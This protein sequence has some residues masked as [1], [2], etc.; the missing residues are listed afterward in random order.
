[1]RDPMSFKGH[2]SKFKNH[3]DANL[4]NLE[5]HIFLVALEGA[6]YSVDLGIPLDFVDAADGT[7][8]S[9]LSHILPSWVPEAAC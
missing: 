5:K 4:L 6:A 3:H 2:S 1:M 9:L 8:T 7:E